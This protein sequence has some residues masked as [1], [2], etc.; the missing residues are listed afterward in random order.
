MAFE[1]VRP[2]SRGEEQTAQLMCWLGRLWM[3]R[4]LPLAHFLPRRHLPGD[5]EMSPAEMRARL[6]GL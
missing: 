6:R 1:L 3:D 4:P 2:P 5:G